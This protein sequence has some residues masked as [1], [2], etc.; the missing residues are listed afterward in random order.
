MSKDLCT[1]KYQEA[2]ELFIR[3]SDKM[4]IDSNF[5]YLYPIG[6]SAAEMAGYNNT[7]GVSNG[8]L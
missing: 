4:E 1:C 2:F 7:R 6:L 3:R 5:M 8:A